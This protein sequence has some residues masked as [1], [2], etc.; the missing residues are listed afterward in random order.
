MDN[1]IEFGTREIRIS[2]PMFRQFQDIVDVAMNRVMALMVEE[3]REKG[4]VGA[5]IEFQL[6]KVMN[7]DGTT[8]IRPKIGFKVSYD[9]PRKGKMTGAAP[10]D[11]F[12]GKDRNGGYILS[13]TQITI[14][15][16]MKDAG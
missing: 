14:D 8:S 16:L 1:G 15:D 2:S 7:N 6:E 4:S 10:L 9:V 13:D 12:L 3:G 5:K 11:L